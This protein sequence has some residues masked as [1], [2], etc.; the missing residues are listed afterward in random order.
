MFKYIRIWTIT[1]NK[2]DLGL[3]PKDRNHTIFGRIKFNK[4]RYNFL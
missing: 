1:L 4:M 3:I 2:V